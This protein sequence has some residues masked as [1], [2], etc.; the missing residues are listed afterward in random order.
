MAELILGNKILDK[1]KWFHE[2]GFTWALKESSL[3]NLAF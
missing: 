2:F 1:E 3:Q